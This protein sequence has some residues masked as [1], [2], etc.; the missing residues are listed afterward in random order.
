MN[1]PVIRASE[2]GS[3]LFCE[4]AWWYQRRGIQSANVRELAGGVRAHDAHASQRRQ[5]VVLRRLALLLLLAA[6]AV[7]LM[8]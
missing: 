2:I 3:Y 5:V 7:L 1:K 4:R 8:R 6:V